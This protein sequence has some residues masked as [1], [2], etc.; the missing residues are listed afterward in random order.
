MQSCNRNNRCV[1]GSGKSPS[2]DAEKANGTCKAPCSKDA[3]K[4]TEDR[5]SGNS[6]TNVF[7]V[8]AKVLLVSFVK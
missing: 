5:L 6:T 4:V 2:V 7:S 1:A 8:E 3:K